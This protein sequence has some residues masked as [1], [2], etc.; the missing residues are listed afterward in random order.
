[1]N[2]RDKKK[3]HLLLEACVWAVNCK[4]IISKSCAFDDKF[5]LLKLLEGR[6]V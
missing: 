3:D 4:E 6:D 5:D 1:M 2:Y